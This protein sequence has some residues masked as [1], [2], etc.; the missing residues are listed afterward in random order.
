MRSERRAKTVNISKVEKAEQMVLLIRVWKE[1]AQSRTTP[2]TWVKGETE[3]W[4]SKVCTPGLKQKSR[5]KG[6][7]ERWKNI[8]KESDYSSE[9]LIICKR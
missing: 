2:L 7:Q 5:I 8:K 1:R 3:E 4:G 9:I 6:A